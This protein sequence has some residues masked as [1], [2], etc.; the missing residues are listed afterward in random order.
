M[1]RFKV[2]KWLLS[3]AILSMS[4]LTVMAGA[5]IAPALGVIQQHFNNTSPMLIQMLISVPALFIILTNFWFSSLC[6]RFNTRTLV[7]SSLALYVIA[8]AGAFFLKNLWVILFMRALLGISVG[9]IMPLSTGLLTFYFDARKQAK[10]MGLSSSMNYLGGVI[11]TIIT[12]ILANI[13]WDLS[14]LVYLMGLIAF[15]LCACYLPVSKLPV[16]EGRTFSKTNFSRY[17]SYLVSML[18]VMPIFFIYPTNFS[19]LATQDQIISSWTIAPIMAVLDVIAFW[20]GLQFSSIYRRC[21]NATHLL[22]P[23]FYAVGY[24]ILLLSPGYAAVLAGSILIGVGSGLGIPLI[25]ATASQAAGKEA[26][27]TVIPMLSAALYVGQFLTP[28]L[29][30]WGRK[31]LPCSHQAYWVGILLSALLLLQ[32]LKK[33]HIHSCLYRRFRK[34]H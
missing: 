23:L 9:I 19:I 12:G 18:L 32:V 28:L 17:G 13:S 5:A 21:G 22:P 8:G 33:V 30:D 31:L 14:F 11:A 4:L 24:A 7:L 29:V 27:T 34:I 1:T 15:L 2:T 6:K 20:M 3:T 25:Y 10:L 26:A 16:H